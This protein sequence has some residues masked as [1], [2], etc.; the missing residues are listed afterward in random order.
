MMLCSK[1]RCQKFFRL[2]LFSYKIRPK[3]FIQLTGEAWRGDDTPTLND[4]TYAP[5][6]TTTTTTTTLN[7]KP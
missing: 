6:P 3:T 5:I 2:K 7:P 1:L 4:N